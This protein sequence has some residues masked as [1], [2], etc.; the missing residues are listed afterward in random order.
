MC[1]NRMNRPPQRQS[2]RISQGKANGPTSTCR[3]HNRLRAARGTLHLGGR[4]ALCYTIA[5]YMF[6]SRCQ[7]GGWAAAA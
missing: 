2:P 7:M 5:F 3:A 6:L 4:R 1:S